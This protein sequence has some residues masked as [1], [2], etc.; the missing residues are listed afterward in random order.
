MLHPDLI[1]ELLTLVEDEETILDKLAHSLGLE[2]YEVE[3]AEGVTLYDA[4]GRPVK[5]HICGRTDR[6]QR[7]NEAV[8]VCDHTREMNLPIRAVSSVR[9]SE[10][11]C[12]ED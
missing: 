4:A 11:Y 7:E 1:D 3:P 9:A 8:W 6:W 10:V 12:R 2:D 5:C